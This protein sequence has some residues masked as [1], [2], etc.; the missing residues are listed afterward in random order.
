MFHHDRVWCVTA[1]A[2][3]EDLARKLTEITW[4]C[5]TAF[6]LG[7]YLWLNDATSPDGGQEYSVLKRFG[8]G[9]RPLQVES[10]TFSWCDHATALEYIQRTLRGED[11]ENSFAREV[12]PHLQKPAEHG[13]CHHCA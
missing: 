1:A 4:T 12:E 6:E 7:G 5:C 9:G 2:S 13:R 8:P 10:I 11:D 3:A